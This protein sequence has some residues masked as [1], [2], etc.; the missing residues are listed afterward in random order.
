LLFEK[1]TCCSPFGS[2]LRAP[3]LGS[4]RRAPRADPV[5]FLWYALRRRSHFLSPV[6]QPGRLRLPA[7]PSPSTPWPPPLS[8]CWEHM[9]V[10]MWRPRERARGEKA[11]DCKLPGLVTMTARSSP[12]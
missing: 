4:T 5:G 12:P 2:P 10:S 9:S 8:V 1:D 7:A 6:Q 3:E 11:T